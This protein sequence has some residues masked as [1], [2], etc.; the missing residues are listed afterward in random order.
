MHFSNEFLCVAHVVIFSIAMTFLAELEQDPFD[1]EEFIERL[2]WRA[3]NGK[4]DDVDLISEAFENGIKDLKAIYDTNQKKCE[5]LEMIC[6]EEEKGHWIKVTELQQKCKDSLATFEKL[7]KRLDIVADKVVYLGEQLEGVNTPRMRAV[8]AQ[9]LMQ[10][11]ARYLETPSETLN[12]FEEL[13][14]ENVNQLF[15]EADIIQKLYLISQELPNNSKFDKA[16]EFISKK[17]NLIEKRLIEEFSQAQ[18]NDDRNK[19]KKIASMLSHF[20]G[21]S[22][23]VDMGMFLGENIF[24]DIVPLCVKN[25]KTI[26]EV[27]TNPEQ[28]MSKFVLNIFHGKIQEFIQARINENDTREFL[29]EL[30]TLFHK[31]NKLIEQIAKLKFLGCD[32]NFLNKITRN[33]FNNYLDMYIQRETNYLRDKCAYILQ[34][35]YESK[36]HQKRPFTTGGFQELIQSKIGRTNINIGNLNINISNP[37]YT[38]GE[39]FLSEEIAISILQE[40]KMSLQRCHLL[41]KQ[42]DIAQN[43][44]SIYEIELQSLC[45]EHIDYAIELGLQAIPSAET[46]S[47]PDIHFFDIIRQ[48]NE[49]CHLNEKQ[50]VNWVL[51]LISST[52][53]YSECIKRKRE[54]YQQMEAK[55]NQGLEKSIASIIGWIKYLLQNE[56][57]KTDFKPEQENDDIITTSTIACNKVVKFINFYHNRITKCLDG[58]NVQ[59]VLTDLGVKIHRTINEHLQQYQFNF[60]GAMVVICDVKE[61]RNCIDKFKIPL[62]SKLFNILHALCNLLIVV[63][64][65]LKQVSNGDQLVSGEFRC[66]M[67][68]SNSIGENLAIINEKIKK[69]YDGVPNNPNKYPTLLAV[70]KIKSK[71]LII[72]AYQHGQRHFGENYIQELYDKANDPEVIAKCPEIKWHMIGHVQTNKINKLLEV[73]HLFNKP[74]NEIELSMG[75]TTDFEHAIALGSTMVRVGTA[76]FGVPILQGLLVLRTCSWI[77]SS[78]RSIGTDFFCGNNA[79]H[80]GVANVKLK[81]NQ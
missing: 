80:N 16:K 5:R 41:S 65:N 68:L 11:F 77:S 4:F 59:D 6:R 79:Q 33:I 1:G 32:Y 45:I 51:P 26:K 12:S 72:D 27:F 67:A 46:K 23:C 43:A 66:M 36:N 58:K 63:P 34:S 29:T 44:L 52:T 2:A 28:V 81:S 53:K 24:N 76:I 70:S 62:L 8:E 73:C 39:T 3:T 42:Q 78:N 54:V 37:D 35:Y 15:E 75:M 13:Y 21:Y 17:Y 48:S 19:M 10:H 69:A 31:T 50:F 47:Q 56:Q 7:D 40:T 55:L 30:Y 71:E 57:K 20:K 49:I 64:E 9:K 18:K 22:Q 25:Q 61:Y 14:I 60:M 74:E 38:Q